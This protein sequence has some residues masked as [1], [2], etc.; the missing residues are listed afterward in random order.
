VPHIYNQNL[1]LLIAFTMWGIPP[2]HHPQ[3][4][5]HEGQNKYIKKKLLAHAA[6]NGG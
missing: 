2:S 3:E 6:L 4:D 1:R 5:D